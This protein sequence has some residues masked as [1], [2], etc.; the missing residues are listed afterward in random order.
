MPP[1]PLL[2]LLALLGL[3]ACADAPRPLADYDHDQRF[4]PGVE[5]R[6]AAAVFVEGAN[7]GLDRAD[8]AALADLA[9]EH[10][11]R[12]AG[13]VAVT[14]SHDAEAEAARA[15]GERI[16]AG[17]A[18][19]GVTDVEL[20]LAPAPG[21]AERFASVSVPVW[22]ATVPECGAWPEAVSPDYRNQNTANFG[23]ATARNLG[24]MVA[25]P[26]DLARAR[27]STGRS[28]IRAEDVLTKYGAGKATGSKTEDA[29]PAATLST[30]GAGR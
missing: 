8:R 6:E 26:A 14:V 4:R 12:G 28:A 2:A 5:R 17:F 25:N 11:R 15:F 27:D 7:G 3:A 29:R 30:V 10:L 18:E 9:A 23:C 20:R 13:A 16:A 1:R 21:A 22:V 19:A 24:L